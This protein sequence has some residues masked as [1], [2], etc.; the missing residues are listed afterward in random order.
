MMMMMI[1]I[2][3]TISHRGGRLEL[4]VQMKAEPYQ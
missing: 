2:I 3:I 4:A 1:I